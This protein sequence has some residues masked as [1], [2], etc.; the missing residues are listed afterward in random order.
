M[1]CIV[2]TMVTDPEALRIVREALANMPKLKEVKP[3]ADHRL[4]LAYENGERRIFNVEPYLKDG[5]FGNL[6][7]PEYFADVHLS[8]DNSGIQWPDGQNIAPY[9]LYV[10]SIVA[11]E[12][13]L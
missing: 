11:P 4:L 12:A 3:L 8:A 1:R 5:W 9:K 10:L 7:D 6:R 13:D 2:H